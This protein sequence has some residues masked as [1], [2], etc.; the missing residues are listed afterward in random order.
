MMGPMEG[1]MGGRVG[2]TPA[3]KIATVAVMTAV[4]TVFTLLVRIP[5]PATGGYWHFGDSA[6]FFAAFALGPFSA[7]IAG[8]LGAALADVLGGYAAWAPLS[9]LAHGVQ[10]L[11]AGLIVGRRREGEGTGWSW[12]LRWVLGAVA[13]VAA[14]VGLYLAGGLLVL[15]GPAALSEVPWNVVQG[16]IGAAI[17]ATLAMVVR[18]AYPPVRDLRW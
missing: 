10:G 7:G 18:R 13:G 12:A 6:I 8:G 2:R 15:V 5:I 17:G 14:M 9:L 4:T 16:S 3:M 1:G 11:L